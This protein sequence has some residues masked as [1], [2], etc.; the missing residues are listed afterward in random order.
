MKITILGTGCI[1]T[2]RACASYLI[3]DNILM[4]CGFGTLKQLLKTSD[5]YLHHEKIQKIKLIL[6]SHYHMDH[7]FDLPCFM[8]KL[9]T[10]K[11]PD[12]KVTIICPPGG[13]ERIKEVCRL[14]W[15]D[16]S[17]EKLKFDKY[18][19][20]VDASKMDKFEFE[21]FEITSMKMDHGSIEDY[22][23]V[24]K[25]KS[26]GKVVSFTGDTCMCDNMKKLIDM[27]DLAFVDMAGTDVSHK[28]YNII[29]GIEL[30]KK[31]KNKCTIFP[32]HLTS[33]AYDYSVG[34]INIPKELTIVD[35]NDKVPFDFWTLHKDPAPVV[36]I[37]FDKSRKMFGRVEGQIVD[38][39]L[40]STAHKGSAY[41]TPTYY[42]DVCP[43]GSSLIIGRV[44]YSVIPNDIK[45]HAGNVYM[46][47]DRDY[48]FKS[49]EYECCQLIKKVAQYHEATRLYLTCD[50]SDFGT[51]TVFETLGVKLQ[52]I[53]TSTYYDDKGERHVSE[54][55]IWQ[56][57]F[58]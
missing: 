11:R 24:F 8:D 14:G 5:S 20:F 44:C 33:Q 31:Y 17:Y 9:A 21:D 1:W 2:R 32:C 55:C 15:G 42:F 7:Y 51:R 40:S 29:D 41:N 47:F 38:L 57:E 23:Y 48:N 28:H 54:N 34:R 3:N 12:L 16:V 18:V 58:E 45:G 46:T 39:V 22:G 27:S 26:T 35:S 50:P 43:R 19:T 10:D 13:E 52:E 6:I 25:E 37:D 30:M 56:W 4:D 49:L 36:Q 53:T